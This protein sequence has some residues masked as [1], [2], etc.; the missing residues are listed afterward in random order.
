MKSIVCAALVF[1]FCRVV[2]A[3]ETQAPE[4]RPGDYWVYDVVEERAPQAG[5]GSRSGLDSGT[6]KIE[7]LKDGTL[8]L[9][10]N[11]ARV[12]PS[13]YEGPATKSGIEWYRFPFKVGNTYQTRW[14]SRGWF[15]G[16]VTVVA[17]ENVTVSAGTFEAYKLVLEASRGDSSMRY[18][19]FY[20]P[21]VKG[22][23]KILYKQYGRYGDE[24]LVSRDVKLTSLKVR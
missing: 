21:S 14:E 22:A 1:F 19:Y 17:K 2:A 18:E 13:I 6:Y 8:N 24:V 11:F 3:E 15:Y 4:Y 9:D 20:A 16:T 10:P 7:V 23:V 5:S 12:M